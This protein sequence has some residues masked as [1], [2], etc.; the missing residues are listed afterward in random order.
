MLC[1]GDRSW[2]RGKV[3]MGGGG[4]NIKTVRKWCGWGSVEAGNEVSGVLN[5]LSNY[6]YIFTFI[7]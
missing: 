2:T 3:A 7:I 6:A 5:Q 4:G 1:S